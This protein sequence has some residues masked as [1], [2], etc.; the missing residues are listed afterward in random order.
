[1]FGKKKSP[2]KNAPRIV[3]LRGDGSELFSCLS[4]DYELPE[5]VVIALSIE[6]FSDPEPCEIHRAAVHKRAIMELLDHCEPG[7]DV[8]IAGLPEPMPSYFPEEAVQ[9]R[10]AE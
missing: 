3:L 2:R 7:T 6:Y 5:S 10:I 1:M 4:G 8:A 9:I